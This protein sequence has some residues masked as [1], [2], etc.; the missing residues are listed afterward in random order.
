MN[1]R[2]NVYV[3]GALHLILGAFPPNIQ[4]KALTKVKLIKD[5]ALL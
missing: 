1:E 3:C 5:V 4:D 2:V